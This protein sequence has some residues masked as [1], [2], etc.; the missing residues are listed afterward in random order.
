MWGS[1]YCLNDWRFDK[2]EIFVVETSKSAVIDTACT[3]SVSGEKWYQ[4]SKTNSP[5]DYVAQIESFPLGIVFKFGDATKVKSKESVI[6]PVIISDKN[7]KIKSEIVGE[8]ISLLVS[9]SSLKKAQTV[10]D[11]DNNKATTLGKKLIFINPLAFITVLRFLHQV[12][13]VIWKRFVI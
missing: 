13:V 3:K 12:T 9:K 5:G 7:C 1:K 2:T 11:L 10:I 8:N 6:F 4:N